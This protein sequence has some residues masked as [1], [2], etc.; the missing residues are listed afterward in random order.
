MATP[1]YGRLAQNHT[2]YP[3][4]KE[5]VGF[6]HQLKCMSFSLPRTL[7]IRTKSVLVP[8]QRAYIHTLVSPGNSSFFVQRVGSRGIFTSGLEKSHL[9]MNVEPLQ[10]LLRRWTTSLVVT[11]CSIENSKTMNLQRFRATSKK[12]YVTRWKSWSTKGVYIPLRNSKSR[13][14]QNEVLSMNNRQPQWIYKKRRFFTNFQI[15]YTYISQHFSIV[16]INV[17]G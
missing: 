14:F 2:L 9:R 15:F 5:T 16:P 6:V 11:Q 1:L 13:L 7:I 12:A 4:P 10:S 8:S 3:C 17:D